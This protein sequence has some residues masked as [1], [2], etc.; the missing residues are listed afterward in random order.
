MKR[1]KVIVLC[2]FTMMAAGCDN[3][4][5]VIKPEEFREVIAGFNIDIQDKTDEVDYADAIYRLES[6]TYDFI[7][8]D[9]KKKY[10]IEGLFIDQCKN[11]IDEIGN[12]AHK[13]DTGSG[14]NWAKMQI[15]TE[16]NFYYVSWIGDT[17]IYVKGKM[18][19]STVFK[20]I[21]EKLGY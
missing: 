3:T 2:L 5:T 11:V 18:A 4:K 12:E 15:T 9:G 20:E 21:I 7:Y 16:E 6:D 8:I 10:D 17:Y 1:L 19:D 14:S 13:Q